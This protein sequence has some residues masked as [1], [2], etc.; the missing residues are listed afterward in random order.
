MKLNSLYKIYLLSKMFFDKIPH[1]LAERITFDSMHW[2]FNV[3]KAFKVPSLHCHIASYVHLY[4][5]L[6]FC[7]FCNRPIPS[8]SK[9]ESR[10]SSIPISSTWSETFFTLLSHLV[11]EFAWSTHV[12]LFI[13]YEHFL[14]LKTQVANYH[15]ILS[16]LHFFVSFDFINVD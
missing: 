5:A 4:S 3:S 14:E 16:C 6:R 1:T 8:S 12:W 11:R 13:H 7:N 15:R 2:T 10:C 9:V